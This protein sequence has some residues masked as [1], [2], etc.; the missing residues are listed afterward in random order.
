MRT[1]RCVAQHTRAW[2]PTCANSGE[3]HRFRCVPAR[4]Q[5][6]CKL[7]KVRTALG[8]RKG[9]PWCGSS[10]HDNPRSLGRARAW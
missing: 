7:H 9:L 8:R 4:L 1:R 6:T 10:S 5:R 2:H 3:V